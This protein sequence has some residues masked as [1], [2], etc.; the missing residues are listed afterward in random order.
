[1]T[2]GRWAWGSLFADFNNDG[3]EDL[4]V[5]NGFFTTEDTRR[6]VKLLLATGRVAITGPHVRSWRRIE[7]QPKL[8]GGQQDAPL[9]AIL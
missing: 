4:Y 1:M 8:G 7:L 5:C 6:L 3:W 9:R 2:M